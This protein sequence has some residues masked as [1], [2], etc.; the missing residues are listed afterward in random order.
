MDSSAT[1]VSRG[2]ETAAILGLPVEPAEPFNSY[3]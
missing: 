3:S 1:Y 2:Q